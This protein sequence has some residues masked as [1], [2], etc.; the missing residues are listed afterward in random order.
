MKTLI[1]S[2]S[3]NNVDEESFV[4]NEIG[5]TFTCV[6]ECEKELKTL[7]NEFEHI[8][9]NKKNIQKCLACGEGGWGICW[10]KHICCLKD[11]FN[12]IYLHMSEFDNYVYI[13]P[14]YFWEM[15]ESAKTFFDR[16]KRCD[17]FNNN[18]KIKNKKIV[19]IACAGG[20]GTGTEETL[21]SFDILN[22]YLRTKMVGRIPVN[23]ENFE[24][25]KDL[26]KEVIKNLN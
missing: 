24:T 3:P 4:P 11:E 10:D 1:L 18:S 16:L 13:T 14:V 26:I 2:F 8:C 23:K 17:S 7:N 19:C 5:L 12:D 6:K 25:Q 22:H 20:S 21:K 15:S 9:I